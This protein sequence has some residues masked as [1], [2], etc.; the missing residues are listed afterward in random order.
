ML[1]IHDIDPIRRDAALP[2]LRILP[3]K[4]T[5]VPALQP[6]VPGAK[7]PLHLQ[8]CPDPHPA[9]DELHPLSETTHLSALE[10]NRYGKD[11]FSYPV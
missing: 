11:R 10:L 7:P 8:W 6:F 9:Y 3:D 2:G 5:F 4:E 1:P